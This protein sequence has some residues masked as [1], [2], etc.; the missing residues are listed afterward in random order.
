LKIQAKIV[1]KYESEKMAEAIVKA[2]S[3]DNV[4]YLGKLSVKTFHENCKVVNLIFCREKIGTFIAT[5]DD[6]LRC[7]VVAEKTS[8]LIKRLE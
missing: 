1:L 8:G 2:V 5:I 3:P 7:T 6:L 4:E